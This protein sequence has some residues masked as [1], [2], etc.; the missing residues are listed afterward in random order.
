MGRTGYVAC[1]GKLKETYTTSESENL[2][3]REQS[4]DIRFNWV[5]ILK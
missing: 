1:M 3:G 5:I 2:K 4:G